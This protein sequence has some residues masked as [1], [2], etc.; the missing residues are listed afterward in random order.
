MGDNA[1]PNVL[2]V[3]NNERKHL[4][5]HET[6][7]CISE[8]I[9]SVITQVCKDSKLWIHTNLGRPSFSFIYSFKF[10]CFCILDIWT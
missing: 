4:T 5:Y 9:V 2:K 10:T 7:D 6:T 3:I 1:H 8:Q